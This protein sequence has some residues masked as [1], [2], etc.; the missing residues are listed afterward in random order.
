MSS[1]IISYVKLL[2]SSTKFPAKC[3]SLVPF[4]R[5]EL[6]FVIMSLLYD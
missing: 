1:S 3:F 4:Q 5:N 2:C 6:V